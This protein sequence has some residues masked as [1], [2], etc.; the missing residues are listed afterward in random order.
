[1]SHTGG[2]VNVTNLIRQIAP[3]YGADPRLMI[4]VAKV[5][6]GL[7][8]HAVGD[9]GTSFNLFQAHEGGALPGGQLGQRIRSGDP[10]AAII[11]AARRFKGL[12]TPEQ[13]YGTQRPADRAGYIAKVSSAL[14]GTSPGLNAPVTTSGGGSG[15]MGGGPA[16]AML[17]QLDPKKSAAMRLIFRDKPIMSGLFDLMEGRKQE[18]AMA[19]AAAMPTGMP[20]S[21]TTS[22]GDSTPGDYAGGFNSWRDIQRAGQQLFGLRNDPGNGQTTG[23]GHTTGSE[24]Y[25]GRAVDFGTGLNGPIEPGSPLWRYMNW[26]KAQG[27]DVLNEGDHIHTSL[28][29]SGI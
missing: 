22:T 10:V 4:A 27:L 7:N 3:K 23:G 12:H 16:A 17:P 15:V 24:H 1:M 21:P 20:S 28:P 25:D 29:G 13:A 18:A 9:G 8:P 19:Q 2:N 14:A 6:S 26:A 11:E 5:E